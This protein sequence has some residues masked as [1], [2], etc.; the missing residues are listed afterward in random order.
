VT[1]N[2]PN[3]VILQHRDLREIISGFIRNVLKGKTYSLPVH[4]W[5]LFW[6]PALVLNVIA[7]AIAGTSLSWDDWSL[8]LAYDL[9]C[10]VTIG[11][12]ALSYVGL[13][14]CARRERWRGWAITAVI[15][16]TIAIVRSLVDLI[17]PAT[18]SDLRKEVELL[19]MQLPKQLDD[20]TTLTKVVYDRS[21]SFITF[22]EDI[23]PSYP[24]RSPREMKAEMVNFIC[25]QFKGHYSSVR[26][27]QVIVHINGRLDN[28]VAVGP[29]D[30][31]S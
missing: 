1:D 11:V 14:N 19:N 17:G 27:F 8:A 5:L 26:K 7:L 30:C 2:Q 10:A 12:M 4:F 31:R 9:W 24:L 21:T 15:F 29:D 18:S 3:N 22:M 13:I 23:D 20:A 16:A 25:P 28:V 6:L